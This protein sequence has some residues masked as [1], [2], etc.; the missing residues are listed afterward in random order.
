MQKRL[1]LWKRL[2]PEYKDKFK[3]E[4]K[5]KSYFR[6]KAEHELKTTFYFT[7]VS[8]GTAYVL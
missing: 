5:E 7:E 1:N 8:Y 4:Y 6:D 3:E 2:K